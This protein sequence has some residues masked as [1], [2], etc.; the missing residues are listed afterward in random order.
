MSLLK[1][2]PRLLLLTLLAPI[3]Q[4]FAEAPL[5]DQHVS[6]Y[7]QSDEECAKKGGERVFVKNTHADNMIDLHLDRYFFDVR[8]ADRSMF[9]LQSGAS[10]ALGCN[11][12]FDAEQRWELISATFIT[13]AAA[14][15]RYGD[16]QSFYGD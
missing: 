11:R 8:Q 9:P 10:Q 16:Y 7:T 12:A 2:T 14:A 3:G 15:E 13:E 5:A 4:V 6:F 1:C